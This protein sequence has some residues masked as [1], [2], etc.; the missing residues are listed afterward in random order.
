MQAHYDMAIVGAGPAGLATALLARRAGL[1]VAL[2]ERQPRGFIAAPQP[3][4]RDIALTHR[5]IAI[6][7]D[8]GVWDHIPADEVSP[9]QRAAVRNAGSGDLLSLTAGPADRNALG[10]LVANHVIRKALYD[11]VAEQEGI[12]LIPE[13]AAKSLALEASGAAVTLSSGESLNASLVVAADSRFSETRRMAGIG[14]DMKD[15]GRVCIVC[16]MEHERVHDQ[17]AIEWFDTDQTL[18]A[19]PLNGCQSSIVLTLPSDAAPAAM[20][21]TGEAFAGHVER[22]FRSRWG[23]MQL[24]GK[25]HAYPLVAVYAHRFHARRFALVGDAAVGMHPVTAHGYNF[26][27]RGAASL[28]TEIVRARRGRKDIGSEEA[29]AAYG[30]EHRAATYPLYLA[31]NALVGLYT[32]NGLIAGLARNAL[33]RIGDALTPLKA[34]LVHKLTESGEARSSI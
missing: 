27:L 19:L 14:A 13:A 28:V 17:T 31:T 23:R 32:D 10:S 5:S 33:L 4:G 22:R 9:I 6:L 16:R 1:S 3:D 30:R 15:F 2:I 12:E 34:Y 25:R 21:M 8:M 24:I 18:A 11:L 7:K 29:L 26:G 20:E